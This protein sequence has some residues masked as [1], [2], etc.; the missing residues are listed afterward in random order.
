[1]IVKSWRFSIITL[2]GDVSIA[3]RESSVARGLLRHQGRHRIESPHLIPEALK[4]SFPHY[5]IKWFSCVC[6]NKERHCIR[7]DTAVLDRNRFE[8]SERSRTKIFIKFKDVCH[9]LLT[10]LLTL[11]I[12]SCLVFLALPPPSKIKPS[13]SLSLTSSVNLSN[14]QSTIHH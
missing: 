11:P 8:C 2:A 14:L 10:L 5:L 6:L 9:R 3:Y 13:L 12:Y 1:M 7:V 4:S